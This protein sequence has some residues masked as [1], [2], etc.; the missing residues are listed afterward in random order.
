M[1]ISPQ[2]IVN[3]YEIFTTTGSQI[4]SLIVNG[5][6]FSDSEKGFKENTRLI[7]YFV[8]ND[9]FLDIEFTMPEKAKVEFDI[10]EISYDLLSNKLF[11]IKKRPTNMIPKPFVVNDAI[12]VKKKL[13]FKSEIIDE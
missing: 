2:R 1:F 8:A 13:H 3:R 9:Y 4:K 10:Y 11:K 7:N 12:I 6:T 5:V